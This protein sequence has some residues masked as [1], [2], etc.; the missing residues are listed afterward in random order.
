[1]AA[2][3]EQKKS[4]QV[5]KAFKGVNTKANRTAIDEDQFSWLENAQ[6]IG[7]GNIKIVKAQDNALDNTGNAVAWGN[8]VTYLN[9]LNIIL[10]DY[11]VAFEADGRGE[12]WNVQ[13][14]NIGRVAN[15]STFS[16][17]GVRIA[18]WKNERGLIL[19]PAKGLYS[20]DGTNTVAIGSIGAIGIISGGSGYTSA[21]AVTI[22]APNDPNGK[23]ATATASLVGGAVAAITITEAGTGY[24][25]APSITFTGGDGSGADA[26]VSYI[27]FA[28]GTVYCTV[29]T[30]GTGYTDAANITV[31]FSG[32]GGAGAA[33]TAITS[34]NA[35]SQIVM[36]NLG[37][38]YTSNP[39]VTIAGGGGSDAVVTATAVTDTNV[40]VATFSGRVWVAQGRTIYYSAAGSYND[41]ITVSAGTAVLSDGTLHGNI[42][43]FL[44]A[45]NFL[46]IF[47]DD[48]INVFSDVRVTTTGST[49]FTNTN[50]SASVG[51]KRPN[52]TFPY[53]R[54]VL[55]FNDYGVYALV[56]STTSKISDDLDGVFPLIDFTKPVYG[57]QVLLNNILCAAFNFWYTDPV[58]GSR[59]I[60]AVFF[61]K[62]WFFTSQGTLNYT[63]SVPVG[64]L[65]T[66]Y[67]SSGTNLVKMYSNAT[68]A[69]SSTLQTALWPLGDPIRSKQA[70]KWAI[71]ATTKLPVTLNLT[72]DSETTTSP[73][74]TTSNT[75]VTWY[76]YLGNT[77]PWQNNSLQT[78]G[79]LSGS[80]YQLYKSDAEMYGKYLGLT[81]TSNSAGF[82]YNTLE[83]EHELR[84]RF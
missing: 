27:S 58:L 40:D 53:F 9:S 77:I 29:E 83:M 76:N 23:Q 36:T 52:A 59:P 13:T 49:L 69:I 74:Y 7:F 43:F 5:V 50:V 78:I 22:G 45:N 75:G 32:G 11:V 3:P 19:D 14:G 55:L 38:G 10:N 47:G 21:P 17:A 80:A 15:V 34:N 4:Y 1:M 48:S 56:G 73:S 30:G 63:T 35:I 60:Q 26:V 66:L 79:W 16:A 42:Q 82:V 72:V 70:L 65:V 81:V 67:G 31:S 62:K 2:S 18:Q 68:S 44:S 33:A 84:A 24:T 28:T 8:T 54:S 37:S 25:S 39:T 41:F 6:P 64:G 61:E 71:E 51:S 20:W 57:G 46:Y 12:Y